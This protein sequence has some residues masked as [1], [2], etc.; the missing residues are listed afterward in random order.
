[1]LEGR[2]LTPFE[3]IEI[4]KRMKER[5]IPEEYFDYIRYLHRYAI[6]HKLNLLEAN[7]HALC[8]AKAEE[9]K[10]DPNNKETH[11]MLRRFEYGRIIV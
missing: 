4:V 1:M 11:E 8:K 6:K 9:C 7:E 5:S 10:I 2:Q 3:D